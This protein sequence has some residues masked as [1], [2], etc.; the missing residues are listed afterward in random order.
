MTEVK[1]STFPSGM[2]AH[3]YTNECITP[4]GNGGRE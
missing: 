2:H 3:G 1:P 4:I